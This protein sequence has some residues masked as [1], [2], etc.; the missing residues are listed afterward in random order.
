[1]AKCPE[2]GHTSPESMEWTKPI[3]ASSSQSHSVQLSL[4]VCPSCEAV[5]GGMSSAS[6][7]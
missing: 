2:C 5:L 3:S 4:V 1:M 7:K 6:E